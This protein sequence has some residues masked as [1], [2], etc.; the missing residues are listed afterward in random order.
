M[1]GSGGL[2]QR[3]GKYCRQR[4]WDAKII[5]HLHEQAPVP[6]LPTD[7]APKKR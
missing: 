4:R 5:E 6:A 2:A 1:S 7:P 3:I